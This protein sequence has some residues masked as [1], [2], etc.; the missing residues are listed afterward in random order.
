LYVVLS[1]PFWNS[2]FG[3]AED[4][5]SGSSG[6]A[7]FPGDLAETPSMLTIAEDT[8]GIE[9]EGRAGDAGPFEACPLHA[10]ADSLHDQIAFEFGDRSD[11]A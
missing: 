2:G 9:I 8:C 11:D 7:V 4:S 5:M 10:G 6:D 1:E 3:R